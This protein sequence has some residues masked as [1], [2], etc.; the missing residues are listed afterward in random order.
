MATSIRKAQRENRYI[1]FI[2]QPPL[3]NHSKPLSPEELQI[4]KSLT[5]KQ[6]A[7]ILFK[8]SHKDIGGNCVSEGKTINSSRTKPRLGPSNK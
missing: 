7:Y 4:I 2:K 3:L 6:L 8:E 5:K 1:Y